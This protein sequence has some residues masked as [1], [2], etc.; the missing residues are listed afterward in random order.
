MTE[1]RLVVSSFA[2][3]IYFLCSD[4]G[5]LFSVICL[6]IQNRGSLPHALYHFNPESAFKNPQ[7]KLFA[8]CPLLSALCP[9]PYACDH[10]RNRQFDPSRQTGSL[11]EFIFEFGHFKVK[12]RPIKLNI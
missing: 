2:F 11:L 5:L 8:P 10:F 3:K 12:R 6:S 4:L 9:T 1:F 7:L